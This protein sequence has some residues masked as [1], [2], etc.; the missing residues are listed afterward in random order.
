M[1]PVAD[2][3]T[4][5]TTAQAVKIMGRTGSWIYCPR[6]VLAY[7]E[8][9]GMLQASVDQEPVTEDMQESQR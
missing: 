3:V 7:R 6:L 8:K 1:T 9:S 4:I 5:P 2:V